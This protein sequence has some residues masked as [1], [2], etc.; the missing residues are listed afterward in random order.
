MR[1]M[2]RILFMS[3]VVFC[4]LFLPA[5]DT[6]A[7]GKTIYTSPYVSVTEDGM[8]WTTNPGDRDVQWY[9]WGEKAETGV[10]SSIRAL[11]RGE[12]YYM[13]MRQ[14]IVPV[15]YWKVQWVPGQCIHGSYPATGN[16]YHGIPFGRQVCQR[17]HYSGW[18]PYCADCGENLSN[19][20]V[21]MSREAAATIGYIQMESGMSY[22][23]L[24]P[25]CNN[26]EQARGL[27]TH[28]CKAISYNQYRVRYDANC[29][30]Y[31]GYMRNS[32]H[33]YQ[34]AQI[35]EGETVTPETHL[36]LNS[37]IRAGYVFTGWNTKPDGTGTDY[38][39]GEE[40]L[41]LTDCDYY[42][43]AKAGTVVL[44]AQWKA[45]ES[46]LYIDPNGG[47]YEGIAGITA[48]TQG[49]GTVY[50]VKEESVEP[51]TGHR[52]SFEC[53]GGREV[54]DMTGT[55][56]FT[57]WNMKMPF[58]GDFQ[59]GIYIYRSEVGDSDLLTACYEYD[60]IVLPNTEKPGISFGGWYFDAEF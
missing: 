48:I 36:S 58:H 60:S 55:M 24:C 29:D 51:P 53:N 2:I 15:A 59:E 20:L 46:T 19:A 49:Y 57:E 1:R 52:V 4:G 10:V 21:Y 37:Y 34:N 45:V 30:R 23:Y 27:D 25:F 33:M 16:T 44:Y 47:S 14:G 6:S 38:A 11:E 32:I 26:L 41:N 9:P 40:I 22:Y 56:H 13:A 42:A 7:A 50:R 54:P 17:F 31:V 35:Y 18:I 8:A 39:E 5:F 3:F 28:Y 12:H 43:D